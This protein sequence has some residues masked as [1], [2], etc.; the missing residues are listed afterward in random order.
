MALPLPPIVSWRQPV[1]GVAQR[2][3]ASLQ[4]PMLEKSLERISL[5]QKQT[6]GIAHAGRRRDV[7]T[8]HSTLTEG[9]QSQQRGGRF[10]GSGMPEIE[11]VARVDGIS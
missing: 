1:A 2:F 3:P 5:L 6:I 10:A 11:A 9:G 7:S 8:A 4:P